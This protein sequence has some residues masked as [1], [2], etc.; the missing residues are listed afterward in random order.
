MKS[1][2]QLSRLAVLLITST[3]LGVA[4]AHAQA[5]G[6][7]EYQLKAAFIYNFAKFVDWPAESFPSKDSPVTL[8]I[9]G[10]DPFGAG[11]GAIEGRQ[12]HGR[13]L[14]VRRGV[15]V[16][17][18]GMCN[19]AFVADSEERRYTAFLKTLAPAPVL[20]ISDIEGF[21]ASGGAVGL[22]VAEDRL[23]FDANLATLQRA[24]LK[25]SSHALKLARTVYGM[26]R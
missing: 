8:C 4:H 18:L 19:I 12:V 21:A 22:F 5:S 14:R 23:Q 11:F 26:K 2:L 24:N 3:L 17:D 13:V 7:M 6:P 10:R 9:V 16:E 25:A 1:L 15:A 20:T